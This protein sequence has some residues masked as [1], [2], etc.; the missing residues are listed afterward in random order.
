VAG[1]AGAKAPHSSSAAL[2]DL[3]P[4]E[5]RDLD[6][7]MRSLQAP[8]FNTPMSVD[9]C[10]QTKAACAGCSAASRF[11]Y[12]AVREGRSRQQIET[13]YG[14]RFDA[15]APKPI[16]ISDAPSIGSPAAV[17]TI[18]EWADFQCP[19][20][21]TTVPVLDRL[22]QEYAP[23]VR[24]VFKH[25]PLPFHSNA[26]L[27]ARAAVA[28]QKQGHFWQMHHLLFQ[29]QRSLN[30]PDIDQYARDAGLNIDQFHADLAA[31]ETAAR[32]KREMAEGKRIGVEG[33]PTIF[34]NG[35]QFNLKS[36]DLGADLPDW[37]Q[38]EIEIATGKLVEP[39]PAASSVAPA[40]SVLVP[41]GDRP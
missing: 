36:F 18:V 8:C 38:A 9:Q 11:L 25:N 6:I 23:H 7:L 3:T 34:V 19:Y 21:S 5:R 15:A 39:A 31:P 20:C 1:C 14:M 10:T 29:N 27:A 32:V 35:R 12:K 41:K 4:T 28:A 26:D 22:A 37:V 17:V 30:A 13:S 2:Q 40:P 24:V 33:T 16:D